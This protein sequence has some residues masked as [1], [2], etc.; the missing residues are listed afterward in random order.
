[1]MS[2]SLGSGEKK[3]ANGVVSGHAYSLLDILEFGH[4]GQDVRLL[5]MRNPWGKGEWTGDWSDGSDKWTPELRS[6]YSVV[7][8][9]D[10]T[11]HIPFNAY[12]VN[13][14][15]TTFCMEYSTRY[16]HSNINCSFESE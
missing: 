15:C 14:A 5:K 7:E 16:T 10:G 1:M 6:K 3:N 12:M 8:A 11:F 9:D 4:N 2:A 13:F